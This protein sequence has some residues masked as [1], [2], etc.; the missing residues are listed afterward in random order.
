MGANDGFIE[1][2][3]DT[4]YS[5]QNKASLSI[6]NL[7]VSN[8]LIKVG[9]S[10]D[11]NVILKESL[12]DQKA[13]DLNFNQNTFTLEFSAFLFEKSANIGY[14]HRLK[15][16]NNE[17]Q[18]NDGSNNKATFTNVSPGS[19]TFEVRTIEGNGKL[20]KNIAT[21]NI[22]IKAPWYQSIGALLVYFVIVA[23]ILY[24][25]WRLFRY[26][27]L[28]RFERMERKKMLELIKMKT[29]FFVNVS[30]EFKTPLSLIIGH[31][32]Q[33]VVDEP[34]TAEKKKLQ[35]IQKNAQK[36]H[37]LISQMLDFS[38]DKSTIQL[39]PSETSLV[40]FVKEIFDQFEKEFATNNIN[41]EFISDNISY[42]FL[43]DRVKMESVFTNL[44]SNAL[45]FV[46]P[47]GTIRVAINK[48]EES[49]STI[50]VLI[51]VEDNGFGISEEDLPKVFDRYFKS[52]DSKHLNKEGSGIGLSLVKSIID[53]HGGSVSIQSKKDIGTTVFIRLSTKKIQRFIKTKNE[54]AIDLFNVSKLLNLAEKPTILLIEDNSDI[55]E[56]IV[57]TLSLN[58]NFL[59]A[60]DGK[61]GLEIA[62]KYPLDLIIT[63]ITMP[64]INGLEVCRI[65]KDNMHTAFIPIIVLT[66]KADT[67]TEMN[68][69]LEQ[70]DA[71]IP[72]PFD[73]NYL[74]G[75]ITQLI[76]KKKGNEDK[77]REKDITTPREEVLPSP[78]EKFLKE[79]TSLIEECLQNVD[80]NVT[81]LNQKSGLGDKHIYRKIKQLTGMTVVEYIR[82][83]RLKKAAMFLKQ[84][85]L[86]ISEVLYLVGFSTPSYFTKCFKE[87]Y[88]MTPKEFVLKNKTQNNGQSEI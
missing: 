77:I 52:S 82:N 73:I 20:S 22:K 76:L 83:I 71:F 11:K 30:H 84:D 18:Q 4:I 43:I 65:L 46:T 9:V 1:F 21:L 37:L 16:Y 2:S 66:A 74:S 12:F 79:I 45:K 23:F 3:P 57:E 75:R 42:P 67:L 80:L 28:L 72:K 55:R 59:T 32:S 44:L 24:Q 13:I 6:T 7:L 29:D 62:S 15:E 56:F 58:Y 39:M 8:K 64:G 17:W 70:A 81:T 10:Y 14:A 48:V 54:S 53:E 35:S 50:S 38:N 41:A 27:Q 69:F 5:Q 40:D 61:K 88:G 86:S 47:Q 49:D 26:R 68:A 85:K 78:D 36:I 33:L 34:E 25:F 51:K 63:D 60:E 31:V 19:Y 87:E